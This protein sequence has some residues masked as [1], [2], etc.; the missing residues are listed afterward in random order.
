RVAL[1]VAALAASAGVRYWQGRR[2]DAALAQGK[3]SPFPLGELPL[4]LGPWRG[5]AEVMDPLIARA[6]GCTDHTFR[7]Y[8]DERTGVKL[9]LFVIYGPAVDVFI[10][11]P[12]N[13]YP[14]Q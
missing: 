4:T 1:A 14:A 8:T 3:V 5:S 7:T 13:C 11:S 9:G 10:H 12:G 2:V 6:A